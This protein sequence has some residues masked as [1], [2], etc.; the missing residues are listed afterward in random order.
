M[1]EFADRGNRLH[2]HAGEGFGRFAAVS[3]Y[4]NSLMVSVNFRG[5]EHGRIR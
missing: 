1:R 3:K 5:C 4:A 2:P